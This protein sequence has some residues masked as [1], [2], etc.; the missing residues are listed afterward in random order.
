MAIEVLQAAIVTNIS[1]FFQLFHG[2]YMNQ[3]LYSSD[4]YYFYHSAKQST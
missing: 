3:K 4:V 1:S 2:S